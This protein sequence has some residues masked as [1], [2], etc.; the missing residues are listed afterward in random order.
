MESEG[1]EKAG[2]GSLMSGF[3]EMGIWGRERRIL[4]EWLSPKK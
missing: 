2:V 3:Y 1:T 4:E